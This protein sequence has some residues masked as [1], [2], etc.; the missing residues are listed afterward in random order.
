MVGTWSVV[1]LN[2][3][4]MPALLPAQYGCAQTARGGTLVVSP[5]GRFSALYSYE[6]DCRYFKDTIDRRISGR[7]S[8][9]GGNLVFSA[10][11]GFSKFATA[12]LVGGTINGS[13]LILQSTPAPGMT[14]SMTLQ[15]H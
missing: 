11:S 7:Y 15:R 4:P 9:N 5:D 8:Q 10:D 13:V 6:A 3:S 1:S 14:V 2:N 12:P